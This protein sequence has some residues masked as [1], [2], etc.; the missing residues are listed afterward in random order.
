MILFQNAQI[1]LQ[2]L[3]HVILK[4]QGCD[5]STDENGTEYIL[6]RKQI[7]CSDYTSS[8]MCTR[9]YVENYQTFK[10]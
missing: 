4:E 2:K 3:L 5:Q 7:D 8:E 9:V 1:I 10:L 6:I